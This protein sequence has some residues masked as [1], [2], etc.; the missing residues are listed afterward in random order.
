M[1]LAQGNIIYF[2]ESKKAVDYFSSI[3]YVCPNLSN[4]ADY[5]MNI[6]SIE[7][8]E[9][10]DHDPNDEDNISKSALFIE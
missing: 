1:L 10:P 6:M 4:P 5:F 3:D 2:N 9:M 7:S 8:I